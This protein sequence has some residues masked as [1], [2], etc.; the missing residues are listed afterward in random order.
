MPMLDIHIHIPA[1][2]AVSTVGVPA[3]RPRHELVPTVAEGQ[4]TDERRAR[5]APAGRR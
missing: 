4:C 3:D 1:G 5:S 2:A